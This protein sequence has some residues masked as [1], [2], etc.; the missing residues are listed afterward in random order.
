MIEREIEEE[1]PSKKVREAKQK[2]MDFFVWIL[3]FLV[4]N[5]MDLWILYENKEK[6]VIEQ[7]G[8]MK[9]KKV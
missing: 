2:G 3:R 5:C 1:K 4:W 7:K 6:L 8:D 9:I